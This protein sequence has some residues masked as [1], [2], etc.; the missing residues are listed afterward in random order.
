ME[1]ES[2]KHKDSKSKYYT[3]VTGQHKNDNNDVNHK[4]TTNNKNLKLLV[5]NLEENITKYRLDMQLRDVGRMDELFEK[6]YTI[7]KK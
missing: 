5:R 6:I 1:E 4:R 3:Y 2:R 7:L